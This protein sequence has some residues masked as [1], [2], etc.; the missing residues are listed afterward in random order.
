MI[1]AA[2]NAAQRWQQYYYVP[3]MSLMDM[4]WR[5]ESMQYLAARPFN[6]VWASW[7]LLAL[8]YSFVGYM[9]HGQYQ[10][11][12]LTMLARGL[13]TARRRGSPAASFCRDRSKLN[14][15]KP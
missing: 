8:H 6:K 3:A 14:Y 13:P 11:L 5:F 2:L 15:L 1:A 12:L 10:W 7:A 4:Y 9:F